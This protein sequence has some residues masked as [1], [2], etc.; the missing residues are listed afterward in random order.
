MMNHFTV[1]LVGA[2]AHFLTGWALCSDMIFGRI[3]K[4]NKK[5]CGLHKDMRI[6][7]ALQF[8]ASLALAA[9]TVAA[10]VI[11]EKAQAPSM[12]EDMLS[13]IT[14][15]FFSKENM[16]G[17][18]NALHT[19]IFIWAGFIVP[20]SASE[21]IWCG[22]HWKLWIVEMIAKLLE[23]SVLAVVVTALV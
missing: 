14:S 15:L 11:F 22:H 21:V 3:W 19:A 10:L 1:V 13:K 6:N 18:M 8:A 5:A 23:L 12:I 9:A 4:E 16:K 20:T 2:T 7:L 17:S